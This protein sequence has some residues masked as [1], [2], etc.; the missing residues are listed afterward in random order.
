MGQDPRRERM[1]ALKGD[2][3]NPISGKLKDSV[4]KEMLAVSATTTAWRENTIVVSCSEIAD[5]E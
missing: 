5:T 3:G 4:Q 2:K 1:S